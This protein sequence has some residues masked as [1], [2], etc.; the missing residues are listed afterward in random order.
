ME[1]CRMYLF[2]LA[3]GAKVLSSSSSSAAHWMVPGFRCTAVQTISRSALYCSAACRSAHP[4]CFTASR[5]IAR[6]DL[7]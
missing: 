2:R 5:T 4:F 6:S 7:H 1:M 3:S